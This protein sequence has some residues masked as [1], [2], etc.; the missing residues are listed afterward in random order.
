MV[1]NTRNV[2]A[3]GQAVELGQHP[4]QSWTSNRHHG[5]RSVGHSG[6]ERHAARLRRLQRGSRRGDQA[7]HQ[8]PRK[9]S[10]GAPR[11]SGGPHHRSHVGLREPFPDRQAVSGV[12][13]APLRSVGLADRICRA[14]TVC[15]ALPHAVKVTTAL[16]IS[17]PVTIVLFV[18]NNITVTIQDVLKTG[19]GQGAERAGRRGHKVIR[20]EG[21]LCGGRARG[22]LVPL[23]GRVPR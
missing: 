14:I 1:R 16:E 8:D 9:Q 2:L 22:R 5:C 4:G 21:S 12:Y 11:Q 19:F 17:V 20:A 23:G 3:G 15:V 6:C 13:V 18:T 7:K 10:G